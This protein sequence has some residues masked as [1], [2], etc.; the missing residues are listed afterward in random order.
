MTMQFPKI[1]FAD[2]ILKLLGKKRGVKIP[3]DAYEK[4]G[5]H[6]YVK[7]QKEN[8]WKALTRPRD[9]DLPEGMVDIFSFQSHE[10][11]T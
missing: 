9:R 6:V 8:F 4:F 2:K 10:T 11:I 5:P 3:A 1:S 7:A